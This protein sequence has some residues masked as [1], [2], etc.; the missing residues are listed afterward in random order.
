MRRSRSPAISGDTLTLAGAPAAQGTLTGTT[1]TVI[2]PKTG[3]ARVGGD[4][5][6]VTGGA[7]TLAAGG[8]TSPLVIYGDTSQDGKW[9]SSS[10]TNPVA[11]RF[12]DLLPLTIAGGVVIT[13]NQVMSNDHSHWSLGGLLDGQM[14]RIGGALFTVVSGASTDTLVLSGVPAVQG[15]VGDSDPTKSP[16]VYKKPFNQIGTADDFYYFPT[17]FPYHLSGNDVID[18]S[19]AFSALPASGLGS[20]STGTTA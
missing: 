6:V 10:T 19:R 9:Y 3:T 7:T 13:G 2:D 8:P 4:T 14:V 18:A 16:V 11:P 17:A 12:D 1:V 5:I 15:Q 20:T